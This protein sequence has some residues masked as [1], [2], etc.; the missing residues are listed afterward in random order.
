MRSSEMWRWRIIGGLL[1][2]ALGLAACAPAEEVE[3]GPPL[4]P[5]ERDALARAA[6]DGAKADGFGLVFFQSRYVNLVI[7]GRAGGR[8]VALVAGS[9]DRDFPYW[10]TLPWDNGLL[11]DGSA[12]YHFTHRAQGAALAIEVDVE[13]G[14]S[15]G[16][17]RFKGQMSRASDGAPTSVELDLP[18]SLR[19]FAPFQLGKRYNFLDIDEVPGM[20]WQ[21]CELEAD[22]GSLRIGAGPAVKITGLH[23]ELESGV[24]SNLRARAFA[25]SYDYVAVTRAD[26]QRHALVD[27]TSHALDASGVLGKTLDWYAR[28]F[29]SETLTLSDGRLERGNPLEVARPAPTDSSVLLF[30]A[31]V[32]LGLATLRRQL[33]RTADASGASLYGLREIFVRR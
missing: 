18:V 27:F 1:L 22:A 19:C 3:P 8:D 5:E 20:R 17:I 12:G 6:A 7:A 11:W 14:S 26:G 28:S 29:A 15:T 33:I 21:P 10:Q 16:R 2:G 9:H 31:P 24:V 30:E 23:G 13:Q 32:D 25:L 4:T